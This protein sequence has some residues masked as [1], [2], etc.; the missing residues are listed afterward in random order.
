MDMSL[1][2]TLNNETARLFDITREKTLVYEKTTEVTTRTTERILTVPGSGT[3]G[4]GWGQDDTMALFNQTDRQEVDM[5]VDQ[6]GA[7]NET[8]REI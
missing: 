1:D 2:R 5:S 3:D 8:V 4:G 6:G 7:N